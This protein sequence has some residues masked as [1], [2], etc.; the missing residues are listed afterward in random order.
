VKLLL[1]YSSP[2]DKRKMMFFVE[3]KNVGS[4]IDFVRD[5]DFGERVVLCGQMQLWRVK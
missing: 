2:A 1:Q 5:Y 3:R 4:A